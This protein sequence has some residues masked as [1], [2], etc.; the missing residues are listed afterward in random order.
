MNH[1]EIISITTNTVRQNLNPINITNNN[2]GGNVNVNAKDKKLTSD[3]LIFIVVNLVTTSTATAA[4]I[5]M[6]TA[7]TVLVIN[8]LVIFFFSL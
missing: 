5:T 6:V 4:A 7:I 2:F 3:Q 8:L 1:H